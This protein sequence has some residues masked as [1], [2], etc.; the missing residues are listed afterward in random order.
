[1]QSKSSRNRPLVSQTLLSRNLTRLS[2]LPAN[3]I[4]GIPW[5]HVER[6]LLG[7]ACNELLNDHDIT[8]RVHVDM[9]RERMSW[10][11]VH[12]KAKHSPWQRLRQPEDWK[13]AGLRP[14]VWL[15]RRLCVPSSLYLLTIWYIVATDFFARSASRDFTEHFE[16]FLGFPDLTMGPWRMSQEISHRCTS[17]VSG[18]GSDLLRNTNMAYRQDLIICTG[19][20]QLQTCHGP[21]TT[22]ELI[23]ARLTCVNGVSFPANRG[24]VYRGFASSDMDQIISAGCAVLRI[25]TMPQPWNKP[26]SVKTR[27]SGTVGAGTITL[28]W[29]VISINA[30]LEQ[31]DEADIRI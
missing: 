4:I 30:G 5:H 25:Y 12:G 27:S 14:Q 9:L 22:N 10:R 3:P 15:P 11:V 21:S 1:M 16:V 7:L 19:M 2:S 6:D 20:D 29:H 23:T 17:R 26:K 31:Q 24:R 18:P 13:I 28:L 8:E